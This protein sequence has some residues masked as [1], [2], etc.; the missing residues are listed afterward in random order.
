MTFL[1][2]PKTQQIKIINL[3]NHLRTKF[4]IVAQDEQTKRIGIYD[5]DIWSGVI[6]PRK[7]QIVNVTL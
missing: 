3:E 6:E 7:T 4:E 2:H 5:A 1:C